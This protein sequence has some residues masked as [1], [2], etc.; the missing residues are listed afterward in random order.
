MKGKTT[1]TGRGL[2]RRSRQRERILALLRS[3]ESHPTAA[4]V[5]DRLK[6]EFPSLSVGTVYRNIAILV[7]EGLVNRI[8][9]GSTFDRYDANTAPHYH[10]IC[11]EC[12]RIIDVTAPF[13]PAITARVDPSSGLQVR[14]HEIEFYGLCEK[15]SKER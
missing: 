2:H 4:W 6:R 14:R 5:Y 10:F 13:D 9:F 7:E 8:D 11:E 12:G 3:T 15:C 1:S